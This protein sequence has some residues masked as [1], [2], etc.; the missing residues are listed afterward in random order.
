MHSTLIM[1]HTLLI[2][3]PL[4]IFQVITS[5]QLSQERGELYAEGGCF[6]VTSRILIVDLLDGKVDPKLITGILIPN[7]QR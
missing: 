4:M 2:A 6:L 7:A 3:H 5:S 1:H